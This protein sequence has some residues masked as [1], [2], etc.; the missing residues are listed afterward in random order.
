[1]LG[2]TPPPVVRITLQAEFTSAHIFASHLM[3]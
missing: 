1:M 3:L 2:T